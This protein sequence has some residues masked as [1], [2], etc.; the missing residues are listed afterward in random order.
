MGSRLLIAAIF[1]PVILWILLFAP[2]GIFLLG[3]EAVIGISLYE[4]YTMIEGKKIKVYKKSGITIGLCIPILYYLAVSNK[5]KYER[6][7]YILIVLIIIYFITRQVV[8]G[9]I[10]EAIR[11]ISYTL[12]GILYISLLLSHIY[13]IKNISDTMIKFG[14]GKYTMDVPEGRMW[15]LTMFLLV[16]ASDSAAY[17]IGKKFGKN[18]ILP[19]ISP[20]KSVEGSI[21]GFLAPIASMIIIKYW[22]FP[23]ITMIDTI[24]IGVIVGVF[25]Q[26]GDFG[27]SLFKREFDIKDSSNLLMG[28]GG[29]WDRFDSIIFVAPL[30]YYYIKLFIIQ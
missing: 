13:F 2:D 27:E 11:E 18:K 4:F 9:E 24:V 14:F 20:K 12:F 7:T 25:G 22:Y 29:M 5:V 17:F 6:L 16:W 26:I 21:I 23:N 30:L 3:L 28:H 1:I 8:L 19:K 15:V 10:K